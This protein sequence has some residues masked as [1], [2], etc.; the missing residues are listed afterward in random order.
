M[1]Q[2]KASRAQR[3]AVMR[4]TGL[5]LERQYR[6]DARPVVTAASPSTRQAAARVVSDENSAI[7]DNPAAA[8]LARGRCAAVRQASAEAPASRP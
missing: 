3:W 6:Q 4:L 1:V 8:R 7:N 2:E 5:F